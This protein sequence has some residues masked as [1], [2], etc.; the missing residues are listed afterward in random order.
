ME[1]GCHGQLYH[2]MENYGVFYEETIGI[3]VRELLNGLVYLH[4][5]DVIHRDLKP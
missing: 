4:N 2:T 3:L 5:E 1:L